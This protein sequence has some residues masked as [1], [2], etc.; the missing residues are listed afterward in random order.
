MIGSQIA[1][2]SMSWFQKYSKMLFTKAVCSACTLTSFSC[3]ATNYIGYTLRALCWRLFTVQC[4]ISDIIEH[5]TTTF[6]K[7]KNIW[8]ISLLR[9]L[10]CIATKLEITIIRNVKPSWM[11]NALWNRSLSFWAS[12]RLVRIKRH[13][14]W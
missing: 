11:R 9:I 12:K 10:H 2:K 4:C 1:R 7:K 14:I 3:L 6:A 13:E 5:H 8:A